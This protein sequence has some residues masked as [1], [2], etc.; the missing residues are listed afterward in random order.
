MPG[1]I[2]SVLEENGSVKDKIVIQE[3]VFKR[4]ATIEIAL[5]MESAK[6]DKLYPR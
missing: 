5:K 1:Q 6:R 4:R 2:I 3:I